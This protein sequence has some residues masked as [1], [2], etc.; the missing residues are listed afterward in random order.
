MPLT[1]E[2]AARGLHLSIIAPYYVPAPGG[3]ARYYSA[4]SASLLEHGIVQSVEIYTE[5]FPGMPRVETAQ[6]GRLTI[7]RVF[8]YRAGNLGMS[9]GAALLYIYQN[10]LLSTLGLRI[11]ARDRVVLVH[12]YFH[13][14]PGLVS[15]VPLV[16]RRRG[17]GSSPIIVDLRDPKLPRWAFKTLYAYDAVICC[18]ENIR[19]L[20]STD[21]R[22]AR[23]SEVIPIPL[24]VRRPSDEEIDGVLAKYGLQRGSYVYS[25]NGVQADKN[26]DEILGLV[27]GLRAR[28][29]DLTLVVAGRRRDWGSQHDSAQAQGELQYLGL[30]SH[31]ESLALS[32]GSALVPI[33]SPT[34][35]GMPRSALE[36][37]AVGVPVLLPKNVPEFRR[38][39]AEQIVESVSVRDLVALAERVMAGSNGRYDFSKHRLDV[40]ARAYGQLF[41]KA[42]ER[43]RSAAR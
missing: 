31:G 28:G 15:L 42:L 27:Q 21:N 12:G 10:L 19:D 36:A 26:I 40:A 6:G 14:R 30:V 9:R 4:L 18:S 22:L 16:Y 3:A 32:S 13:N 33:V 17:G 1:A 29:R 23:M 34:V 20:I 11:P 2:G 39:C 24:E 8:P 38:C 35:E 7:R 43:R 41:E 25:A 5:A 37:L